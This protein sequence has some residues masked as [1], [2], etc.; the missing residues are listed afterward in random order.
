[1]KRIFLMAVTSLALTAAPALAQT[2]DYRATL[3]GNSTVNR[4]G[5]AATASAVVSVDRAAQTVAITMTVAGM[6]VEALWDRLVAAPAGPIHL[7]RYAGSDL[8]DPNSSTLAFPVPFGA[9]FQATDTG[10]TVTTG[11]VPYAQGAATLGLTTSFEDF[12]A[13]MDAGVIVLNIHTD[14]HN[15]G[16]ISGQ[17]IADGASPPPVA[18]SAPADHSGHQ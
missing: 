1:M 13:A 11:A 12:V 15:G 9:G 16:E 4:S 10:F 14:A 17:V 2:T 8:S 6:P 5:S 7:H 18:Y 3:D